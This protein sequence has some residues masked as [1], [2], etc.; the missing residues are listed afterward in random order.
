MSAMLTVDLQNVWNASRQELQKV[1]TGSRWGRL[2]PDT[3]TKP[4][5]FLLALS[6]AA[7]FH[8]PH[9]GEQT[10]FVLVWERPVWWLQLL[11]IIM[12]ALITE[13]SEDTENCLRKAKDLCLLWCN[14]LHSESQ[15]A[16]II[17]LS[18]L[19]HLLPL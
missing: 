11:F 7:A 17:C 5:L 13:M 1:T 10:G 19:P 12:S 16:Q 15:W 8:T 9:A 14:E 18:L 6:Q 3:N 4:L 2:D